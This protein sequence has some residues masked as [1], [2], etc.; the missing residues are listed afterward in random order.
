MLDCRCWFRFGN[1]DSHTEKQNARINTQ[2]VDLHTHIGQFGE[3]LL[4]QCYW[5]T[6]TANCFIH[7]FRV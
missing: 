5:V 7:E 6:N 1:F 3:R 4:A 2:T